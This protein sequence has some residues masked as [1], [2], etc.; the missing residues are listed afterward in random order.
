M[1]PSLLSRNSFKWSYVLNLS[2]VLAYKFNARFDDAWLSWWRNTDRLEKAANSKRGRWCTVFRLTAFNMTLEVRSSTSLTVVSSRTHTKTKTNY[3]Q[4]CDDVKPLCKTLPTH[5]QF[6]CN[7][8][9]LPWSYVSLG[10][11]GKQIPD[12]P[13]GQVKLNFK[14]RL[15]GCS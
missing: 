12:N 2:Y 14:A 3:L 7:V 10:H 5:I 9:T 1:K 4:C 8:T 6:N 11:R 13:Y 15:K